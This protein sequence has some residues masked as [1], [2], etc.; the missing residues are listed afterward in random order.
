[1]SKQAKSK[2]EKRLEHLNLQRELAAQRSNNIGIVTAQLDCEIVGETETTVKLRSRSGY[3]FEIPYRL[4][5]KLAVAFSTLISD[6]KDATDLL[7]KF[8]PTFA[9]F[10]AGES[11]P[12]IGIDYHEVDPTGIIGIGRSY[13][14]LRDG[15]PV[16]E[17][18]DIYLYPLQDE[19]MVRT[20]VD[21]HDA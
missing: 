15:K 3:E 8:K 21:G 6:L 13:R 4:V 10:L 12:I 19:P 5:A 18:P 1:M 2:R 16:S 14:E 11:A 17:F 9:D 20:N 7:R